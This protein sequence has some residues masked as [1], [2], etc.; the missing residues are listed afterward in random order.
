MTFEL[1]AA[2]FWTAKPYTEW[3]DKELQKLMTDSP[4][5]KTTTVTPIV[6]PPAGGNNLPQATNLS[7]GGGG[8]GAAS[9]AATAGGKG[10]SGKGSVGG[11]EGAGGGAGGGGGRGGGG[12][13]QGAQDL[14]Q[15]YV[16]RFMS[17]VPMKQG[18]QKLRLGKEVA[19]ST[20]AKALI[21]REE[22]EY[23]V[24]V[25]IVPPAGGGRGGRRG[26]G[27]DSDAV[28]AAM[29]EC[30]LTAKG[31]DALTPTDVQLHESNGSIDAFLF[32]SKKN[33][34][35]ADDKD[36]E[37]AFKFAGSSVK[38]RFHPKDMVV[39]GKLEM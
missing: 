6:L 32:F 26:S 23:I 24:V 38:E 22:K 20:E 17:A 19:T 27:L 15:T 35:T 33:A 2:D 30:T 16:I 14:T 25:T 39:N 28:K 34:F 36:V 9:N 3:S 12:R 21:E 10:G 31:K 29:Q 4:W 11:A 7:T 37:V 18:A 8:G 1:T 5:A 13:G